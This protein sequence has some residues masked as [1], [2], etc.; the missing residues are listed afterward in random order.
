[1]ATGTSLIVV[2]DGTNESMPTLWLDEIGADDLARVGG[3]AASL[4]EL[5]G[6]GLPVPSAF[7]VT[8]DTIGRSSKRRNRRAAVRGRRCRQR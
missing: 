7:V 3:K 8:A 4:G 1:M 6:A 5:T 2:E